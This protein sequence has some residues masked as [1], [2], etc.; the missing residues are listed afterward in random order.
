MALPERLKGKFRVPAIAA[1]MF[2]VSGPDLIIEAC[3]GG[4]IGA[5][6]A[7]NAR[8]SEDLHS[9]LSAIDQALVAP[10]GTMVSPY[11]VNLT[12]ARNRQERLLGDMAVCAAHETPI[13][14]TSVGHP[15]EAVAMVHAYGGLVFHDVTTLRHA[16]KA[17]EAGVDGLILVCAAPAA[18]PVR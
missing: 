17:I 11:A 6:P 7:L 1:P 8:T 15:G 13:V 2:L 9:W 16:E 10:A 18:M 4:V 12:V 14:I 3:R 5:L